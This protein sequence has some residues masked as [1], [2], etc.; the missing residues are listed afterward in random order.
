MFRTIIY[1]LTFERC[2]FNIRFRV[3]PLT[4]ARAALVGFLDGVV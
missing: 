4:V 1:A 2:R 3:F